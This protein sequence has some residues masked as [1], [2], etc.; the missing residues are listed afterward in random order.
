M[1]SCKYLPVFAHDVMGCSLT[2]W[3]AALVILFMGGNR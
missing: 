3:L 1:C 2:V